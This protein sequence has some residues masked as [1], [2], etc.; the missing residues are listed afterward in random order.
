MKTALL[1]AS[2]AALLPACLSA[3]T[4]VPLRAPVVRTIER[5]I[6]RHDIYVFTDM[7]LSQTS[8]DAFLEESGAVAAL[9]TLD[10]EVS[11]RLLEAAIEDV[12]KRHDAYVTLDIHLDDLSREV[13]LADSER[14]Q[15]LID[16]LPLKEE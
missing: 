9:L 2:A 14:I 6:A 11:A 16:A 5:V 15:G 3:P 12:L 7:R 10:S 1:F 4:T 13:Y 8:V